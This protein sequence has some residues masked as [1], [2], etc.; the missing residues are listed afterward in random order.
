MGLFAIRI[1]GKALLGRHDSRLQQVRP[2]QML[3]IGQKCPGCHFTVTAALLRKPLIERLRADL[4]TVEQVAVREQAHGSGMI[5]RGDELPKHQNVHC[6]CAVDHAELVSVHTE[7]FL[8]CRAQ[9]A[10]QIEQT[11]AQ[12]LAR[13]L[14]AGGI[15]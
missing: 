15:P 7:N 14:V 4:Q 11:S 1:I 3:G 2:G 12:A 9:G 6:N 5:S 8:S 13:V 10:T